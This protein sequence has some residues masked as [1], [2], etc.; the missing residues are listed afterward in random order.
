MTTASTSGATSKSTTTVTSYSPTTATPT[1]SETTF[2]TTQVTTQMACEHKD[3]MEWSET[4]ESPCDEPM[5]FEVT[6]ENG[7]SVIVEALKFVNLVSND[8]APGGE[9]YPDLQVAFTFPSS[10]GSAD[11]TTKYL[12]FVP[13]EPV[14]VIEDDSDDV[15][16]VKGVFALSEFPVSILND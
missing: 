9:K 5:T 11:T 2:I 14:Q 8:T 4:S 7:D 6:D 12:S 1:T 16:T 13:S 10:P 3:D 15:V